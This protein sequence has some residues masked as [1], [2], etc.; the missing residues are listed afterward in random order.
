MRKLAVWWTS[1]RKPPGRDSNRTA[2]PGQRS[3]TAKRAGVSTCM[4]WRRAA[5]LRLER[6]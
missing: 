3:S 6:A 1:S 5:I 4:S 2:T